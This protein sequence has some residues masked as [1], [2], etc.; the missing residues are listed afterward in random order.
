MNTNTLISPT[1]PLNPAAAPEDFSRS[2][3]RLL[4]HIGGWVKAHHSQLSDAYLVPEPDGLMLYAVG[5]EVQYDFLL[6]DELN[7]LSVSMAARGMDIDVTLI[8]K[9][10]SEELSS[11]LD[12]QKG[13][14][15]RIPTS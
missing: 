12:P 13:P 1:G 8:P 6:G 4:S 2:L 14:A 5:S 15:I 9:C 10:S 3:Q 11:F 7:D